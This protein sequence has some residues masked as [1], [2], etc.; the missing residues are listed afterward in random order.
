VLPISRRL[1]LR[2]ASEAHAL[3]Q[4]GGAGKIVLVCQGM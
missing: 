3:A 1:P 4:Q 2:N